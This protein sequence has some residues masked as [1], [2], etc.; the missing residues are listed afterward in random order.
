MLSKYNVS[1]L[2]NPLFKVFRLNLALKFCS[3]LCKIEPVN[4]ASDIAKNLVQHVGKKCAT[5]LGSEF[6]LTFN[7]KVKAIL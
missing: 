4:L 1:T 7:P 2:V 3:S 5:K 6:D